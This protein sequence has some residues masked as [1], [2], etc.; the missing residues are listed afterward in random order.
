MF[1]IGMLH[2]ELFHT[3]FMN[4]FLIGFTLISGEFPSPALSNSTKIKY[5]AGG[6]STASAVNHEGMCG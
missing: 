5:Q 4:I 1:T 2:R 6:L 3:Q